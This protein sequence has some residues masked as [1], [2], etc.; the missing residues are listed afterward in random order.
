MRSRRARSSALA[1][2]PL[3]LTA[4]SA[5]A[6]VM[7][8]ASVLAPLLRGDLGLG[9]TGV[10]AIASAGYLGALVTSRI[11]GRLS[12]SFGPERV[13]AAG[14]AVVLA[15]A[16][17]ASA[18]ST[19]AVFYL[20]IFVIG[21]GYGHVNPATSVLANPAS[22]HLRGLAMSLKQSG[23]PV[24]GMAAGAALPGLGGH[25][26]WRTALA[27]SGLACLLVCAWALRAGRS[28]RLRQTGGNRERAVVLAP[29]RVLLRLPL[30][31]A[32]GPLV[33]GV[34]VT[35]FAMTA[36]YLVEERSY[37]ASQ[38][39][40]GAS[41]LLFG[42][43]LGRPSWGFVSDRFPSHRIGVLQANAVI[44]AAGIAVLPVVPDV[45]VSFLLP[46]IGIGVAGWNGVYMAA[47]AEARA[48]QVGGST[49]TALTLVNV[50]NVLVP[51]GT[52][53]VVEH[54]ASWRIAL[55][56]CAALCLLAACGLVFARE[57]VPSGE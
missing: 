4:L 39:G 32:Y 2:V 23:I 18:A 51:L 56:L 41:L 52:G 28:V 44:G 1:G 8:G 43:L 36:V 7:V 24:G 25:L 29:S 31:Y 19:A 21:G 55:L 30:G 12:D 10:G 49:G 15:G 13:I 20:G 5:C 11:G 50:G 40:F 22:A 34:Q 17:L 26:G 48:D 14:L 45:T 42:G 9:P 53:A 54:L 37:T 47:V 33:A 46:V 57:I 35:L 3:S 38:A 27:V 6:F 16:L